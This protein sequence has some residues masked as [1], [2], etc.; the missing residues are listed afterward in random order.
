[1]PWKESAVPINKFQSLGVIHLSDEDFFSNHIHGITP[2]DTVVVWICLGGDDYRSR[3]RELD[4]KKVLRSMDVRGTD[5]IIHRKSLEFH[6]AVGGFDYWLVGI[7][8]DE[9]NQVLSDNG[10]RGITFTHCTNFDNIEPPSSVFDRK[11]ADV[12][13]SGQMHEKFYPVRWKIATALSQ[14]TN[15]KAHLLPHP[16][17]ERDTAIHPYIGDAYVDFCKLFWTG[18]VGTGQADG[19][20]MKFLE[21]AKSY[22]LPLGNVPTYVDESIRDEVLHVGL[23]EPPEDTIRSISSILSDKDALKSR[24]LRYSK[25]IRD[26]YDVDVVVPVVYDKMLGLNFDF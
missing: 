16:G 13:I 24:I 2:E 12:I 15:I 21:F 22:T 8:N 20:H 25:L 7:P 4:C 1:M 18:A 11:Q 17:Y 3:F 6:R 9:Y 19:L 26:R 23:G 10:I 14:P 5:G